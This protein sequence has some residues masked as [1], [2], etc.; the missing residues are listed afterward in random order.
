MHLGQALFA[1]VDVWLNVPRVPMEASGTSGMKAALN[2][3]PQLGTQDGWWAEGYN[4][5]NG[6]VIPGAPDLED[7][8][9]LDWEHL[10]RILEEDVVPLYYERDERGVPVGWAE[11]MK[12]ALWVAGREFTTERMLHEYVTGYYAPALRGETAGDEPPTA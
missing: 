5:L 4:G 11:R 7:P 1:G 10:F 12:N 3:A 2:L 8:D 9:A 6:W